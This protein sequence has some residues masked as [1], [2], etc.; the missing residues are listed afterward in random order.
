MGYAGVMMLSVA[1]E[2]LIVLKRNFRWL[3]NKHG[4]KSVEFSLSWSW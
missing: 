2:G 3:Q 4:A 1:D